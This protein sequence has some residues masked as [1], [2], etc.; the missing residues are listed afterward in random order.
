MSIIELYVLVYYILRKCFEIH[1]FHLYLT[2]MENDTLFS[3]GLVVK[4][5][6]CEQLCK[7]SQHRNKSAAGWL[8]CL[9]L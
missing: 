1:Q 8:S 9:S 2:F 7:M 4:N 5:I 3:E 6:R